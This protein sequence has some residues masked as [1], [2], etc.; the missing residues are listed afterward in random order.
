LE[1]FGAV[2]GVLAAALILTAI[3][4][5]LA[6]PYPSLLV[7][8]GLA[9][10]FLPFLPMPPRLDPHFALAL[11]LPPILFEAAY[12]TSWRDFRDN[13]RPIAGLAVAV[14]AVTTWAV[15]RVADW[16]IPEM[17]LGSA[18]V[19][20]A[21]VSPPDAAAATAVMDKMRLPRRLVSIVEGESLVNDAA[22]LVIYGFSV[23]AVM[24][25]HFSAQSAVLALLWMTG[26]GIAL[27]LTVGWIATRLAELNHDPLIGIA[28]S[29]LVAFATFLIAE[30]LDVSGVLAVVSA[31][32]FFAWRAPKTLSADKRLNGTAV[33]KLVIFIL[34]SL[35][36][37]L[38]G[39]R[40]PQILGELS[41]YAIGS[42]IADGA[43]I[44]GTVILVRLGWVMGAFMV[45][46]LE[47][48]RARRYFA[49]WR[50][51]LIVG[52]SGMRGPVSLAAAFALP[53]ATDAGAAFPARALILFLAFAVIFGTLVVQ[54][55][56][57]GL[58]IRL[59][60]VEDDGVTEQEERLARLEAAAAA[61]AVIDR[62]AEASAI[63]GNVLDEL[64]LHYAGRLGHLGGEKAQGSETSFDPSLVNS[65]RLAAIQAERDVLFKLRH[66]RKIGDEAFHK[67]ERDLDL[68]ELTIG[69]RPSK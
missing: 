60:R 68:S 14:V 16:L 20:G 41:D 48:G 65:A 8:G 42:L 50:E 28:G 45:L 56:T 58:L 9:F 51:A 30:A 24:T 31:G 3:A 69:L 35:A 38:I 59:L 54:G 40:L 25:G 12:F 1:V 43:I 4:G 13:L 19:L 5:R 33:W 22:A 46:R 2:L 64:R 21:I 67:V 37:I 47:G 7:L 62:M 23:N 6:V 17:P 53:L 32:L 36:F 27:G 18:I 11:F 49:S 10:G 63:A 15:A 44:A 26:G 57:L 39:L 66:D 55:L 29:F 61:I 34:N 52:W